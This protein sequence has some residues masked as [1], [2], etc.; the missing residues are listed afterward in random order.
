[1]PLPEAMANDVL[2]GSDAIRGMVPE[3]SDARSVSLELAALDSL[4]PNWDGEG[5]LPA[6][7][8]AVSSA[9]KYLSISGATSPDDVYL[10]PDGTVVME[11]HTSDGRTVANVRDSKLV[12]ITH[13]NVGKPTRFDTVRL[14]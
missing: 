5:A 4:P 9:M 10:A 3:S 11:W 6:R 1:M 12:E 8:G 13:R 14:A 7:P 2:R